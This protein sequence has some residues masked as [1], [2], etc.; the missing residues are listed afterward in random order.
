MLAVRVLV[1]SHSGHQE[2]R[3]ESMN[4][5]METWDGDE[6]TDATCFSLRRKQ[7]PLQQFGTSGRYATALFVAATKANSLAT[8]EKEVTALNDLVTKDLKFKQFLMDPSMAKSKKLAGVKEFCEGAKFS[9]IMSNFVAAVA[10]NGR[11]PELDRIALR[12]EEQ[13]MASRNEVKC[14]I[15]T[16]HELS[17]AEVTKV[18]ES[19]KGHAPAGSTLKVETQVDP[20]LIGGLTASIGEKF[21][22][23]SLLTTI[24]KYEAVLAAPL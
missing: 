24:K 18:T 16:A 19:I 23:L 8:V 17:A 3:R 1:S 2:L 20:R 13:C 6:T 11:L 5:C 12:F 4:E 10:E 7:A 14:V 22:D 9:P 21:F 15:T